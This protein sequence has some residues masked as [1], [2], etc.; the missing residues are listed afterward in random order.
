LAA[1]S[2]WGG[3][4]M[5]QV[6]RRAM[7]CQFQVFL[8]P[9]QYQ[10]AVEAATEALDLI[11]QLEDQM[12]I[13]R[14]HSEISRINELAAEQSCPVEPRLFD[15]LDRCVQLSDST[16]GAFDITAGPLV[17]LWGFHTRQGH[18]PPNDRIREVLQRV[19]S[20][21][22]EL[23]RNRHTIHFLRRGM[24]L[25]LGSVGKGYALDRCSEILESAGVADFMIHGGHSSILARGVRQ[26]GDERQDWRVALRHPLRPERRVA[27]IRLCDSGLGTSGSG[28]QFFYHQGRRYGHVLDPR[29]GV[30]SEGVLSATVLAPCAADADA[31]AT[32]FFVLGVDR[33]REY[34]KHR[35]DLSVVFILPGSRQ[36]TVALEMI[37]ID[38]EVVVLDE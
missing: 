28:Q 6:G 5:V 38:N 13:Y 27:E 17:R 3:D 25:N 37:G 11:D 19:G 29:T 22:L 36:G 34:C 12:T 4:A 31:L 30:P 32:T 2:G 35:P 18:F 15:L 24:E 21:F 20:K 23:D 10:G 8:K 26:A 14:P 9:A 1:D 33:T 16:G 7:A